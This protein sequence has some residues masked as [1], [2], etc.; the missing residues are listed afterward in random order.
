VSVGQ[1]TRKEGKE[2]ERYKRNENRKREKNP[3]I[4]AEWA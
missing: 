1:G 4:F 3:V 2:E